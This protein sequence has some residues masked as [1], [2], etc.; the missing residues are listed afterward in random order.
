MIGA[1]LLASVLQQA[2]KAFVENPVSTQEGVHFHA[3][4]EVGALALPSGAGANGLDGFGVVFPRLSVRGGDEFEFELGAPLRLRVLDREPLKDA[5]DYGGY[6]RRQDWDERSDIGQLLRVLRVGRDD[7]AFQ[8]RAGA[9]TTWTLGAGWLV[10]RYNNGLSP[11]YHP[12]GA[13]FIA[14]LGPTRVELFASDVLAGRLFAGEFRLDLGR[15]LS[16]EQTAF[17]RFLLSVDVAHDQGNAGVKSHELSAASVGLQAGVV[18]SD[19]LQLWLQAAA[20]ARADT[21]IESVPDFGAAFGVVARGTP[22]ETLDITGRL[23]G[24]HQAGRFRFGFF[25]A[26]YELA[27]FSGVGLREAP[28]AEEV[29]PGTFSG[30]G[31]VA[32]RVTP[33][34]D[35]DLALNVSASGEYFVTTGRVD[36]DA[37]LQATLPG[38]NTVGE[39]RVILT[40]VTGMPR[41]SVATE[42][43]HRFLPAVYGVASVGTVH[44]PQ[45]D[46]ESV[47]LVRG[48]TAGLGVGVDFER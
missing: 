1:L 39:L 17:D 10:N 13:N 2:P 8:L 20:G 46:G 22:S 4:L 19:T 45:V 47:R 15:V 29:L 27:R 42:L 6:L 44:F 23:E 43:R 7:G 35:G 3:A 21:L 24:R 48:F 25:G 16:D 18:R 31:E 41:Y 40:D 36:A 38:G 5:P 28:L 12:A 9:Y 30:Y 34:A 33:V 37:A 32:A 14:Y 26:G 11:D